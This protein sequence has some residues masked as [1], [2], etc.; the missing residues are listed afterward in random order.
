MTCVGEGGHGSFFI[1]LKNDIARETRV[2]VSYQ[3]CQ[4]GG[5]RKEGA[6]PKSLCAE[7][8]RR[9]RILTKENTGTNWTTTL[10]GNEAI[11]P[12]NRHLL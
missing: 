2:I 8:V 6:F 7:K 12:S 9:C 4:M 1:P 11:G 10:A 3:E 5:K